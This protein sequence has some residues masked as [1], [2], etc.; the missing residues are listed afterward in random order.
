MFL[1]PP[2]SRENFHYSN[3]DFYVTSSNQNQHRRAT[4]P[5]LQALFHPLPGQPPTAKDPPAHW[6]KAQL[7]HYGLQPSDNKGTAAKRLLDALNQGRLEIPVNLQQL[8]RDLK[9]E[10]DSNERKARKELAAAEKAKKAKE[11]TVTSKQTG[12]GI[13]RKAADDGQD[14]AA[15][16]VAAGLKGINANTVNIN[17]NLGGSS[18]SKGASTSSA[19]RA[20]KEMENDSNNGKEPKKT[21]KRKSTAAAAADNE[22]K[23]PARKLQTARCTGRAGYSGVQ[24]ARSTSKAETEPKTTSDHAPVRKRQT[25]RRG[26]GAYPGIQSRPT[27]TA[28]AT[29]AITDD[30]PKPTAK[31]QTAKCSS[32]GGHSGAQ[33]RSTSE[34]QDFYWGMREESEGIE[35][36]ADDSHYWQR[37][38]SQGIEHPADGSHYW[39]REE[40]Q[41][42]EHP[43]DS[44]YWDRE[45]SYSNDPY[46]YHSDEDVEMGDAW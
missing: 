31:K 30:A 7:L 18:S 36:P 4:I 20:K 19:K 11:G 43:A 9:K 16:I 23:T 5:E 42:I 26:R 24:S 1:T 34:S 28:A 13:K 12:K 17:V 14:I 41:G 2:V 22:P 33:P 38:E 29:S 37:E 46:Y 27:T 40:S 44:F 39:H 45:D 3:G 6:Y 21:T 10:W 32:R 8:E 35:R 15:A 25:A